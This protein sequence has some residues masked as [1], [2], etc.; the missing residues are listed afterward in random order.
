MCWIRHRRRRQRRQQ[1]AL[2]PPTTEQTSRLLA[3]DRDPTREDLAYPYTNQEREYRR[4]QIA[5][6]RARG[7]LDDEWEDRLYS[8][9]MRSASVRLPEDEVGTSYGIRERAFAAAGVYG[10]TPV[11]RGPP[12]TG[13]GRGSA[14]GSTQVPTITP[15]NA[16]IGA[17]ARSS[18][19]P[20]KDTR[21]TE[22]T[23]ESSAIHMYAAGGRSR[24]GS[25]EATDDLFYHQTS[26]G[27]GPSP[28]ASSADLHF[29]QRLG[30]QG[31]TG[32]AAIAAARAA[33]R[34]VP[35]SK[36]ESAESNHLP[37]TEAP[38]TRNLEE[39]PRAA[40]AYPESPVSDDQENSRLMPEHEGVEPSVTVMSDTS[41][42]QQSQSSRESGLSRWIHG[43]D[44]STRGSQHTPILQR[45]LHRVMGNRLSTQPAFAIV[46]PS[47]TEPET[48]Q[49][50]PPSGNRVP[51]RDF[52]FGN[53][54][55]F[56][57]PPV[58]TGYSSGA[59]T[60]RDD[61]RRWG[62]LL[63][64]RLSSG[65]TSGAP[66]DS[67]NLSAHGSGVDSNA[68]SQIEGSQNPARAL[69]APIMANR[70]IM[71]QMKERA[72][73]PGTS[74]LLGFGL[75][76]PPPSAFPS[77]KNTSV[78][79]SNRSTVY[80][81]ARST[82][83]TPMGTLGDGRDRSPSPLTRYDS[84][85][86]Q[87]ITAL[88]N[89]QSAQSLQS[90]PFLPPGLFDQSDSE[91][92][93]ALDSPP[94]M[95]MRDVRQAR[96]LNTIFSV[97]TAETYDTAHS[98]LSLGRAFLQ[99]DPT[100]VPPPGFDPAPRIARSVPS[101]VAPSEA[102]DADLGVGAYDSIGRT[103]SNWRRDHSIVEDVLEEEPPMAASQWR[104]LSTNPRDDNG[105]GRGVQEQSG[106]PT[107]DYLN[108]R[109]TLGQV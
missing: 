35:S 1:E 80:Y 76:P 41:P 50:T 15:A 88:R 71:P 97:G 20:R 99:D 92:M 70:D 106:N 45:V 34:R 89:A 40:I 6:M 56:P 62:G 32:V 68:A 28:V 10:Y 86:P 51:S 47:A 16:G 11:P 3:G 38:H 55:L 8:P 83:S 79:S 46:P 90:S 95:P 74:S 7:E 31:A 72:P 64:S 66:R 101:D 39:L 82:T 107:R 69:G 67:A 57:R 33:R 36:S 60:A 19:T 96:S 4:S 18:P 12:S 2:P 84:P 104:A 73:T 103:S 14:G 98:P 109:L 105:S 87:P 48:E 77:D 85:P 17:A 93:D 63:P 100:R 108:W 24:T 42:R 25:N 49:Y 22:A 78:I 30:S 5:M 58:H 23:N 37:P 44:R 53:G 91:P 102:A 43:S 94:P 65:N 61:M 21:S 59:N 54:L 81:D 27:E 75:R 9:S 29:L 13:T 26:E 52:D